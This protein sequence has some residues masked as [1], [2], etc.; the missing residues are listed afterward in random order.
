M[1][2]YLYV[3]LLF[4][5]IIF[6]LLLYIVSYDSKNISNQISEINR[7]IIKEKNE[8]LTLQAEL[9]LLSQPDRIQNLSNN[10]GLNLQPVRVSQI[11]DIED[12]PIKPANKIM[13]ELVERSLVGFSEN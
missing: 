12:I 1:I 2:R 10:L 3:F 5:S 4:S 11:K 9:S 13:D 8:I 7:N 6:A